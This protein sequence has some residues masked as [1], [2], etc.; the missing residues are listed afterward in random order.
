MLALLL[1][2]GS[3]G[4]PLPPAFVALNSSAGFDLLV[5]SSTLR[6]AYTQAIVHFV[7]QQDGGSCFRASASVVLNALAAYGVSPPDEPG[8]FWQT[9]KPRYWVQ[10]NVVNSS[11]AKSNCSTSPYPN[12]VGA[13]LDEA[14][15]AMGC[16]GVRVATLHARS[17]GFNSS[18]DLARLLSD[19]L[20][21]EGVQVIV[22]F[23]GTPMDG[24]VHGGHYSPV[25]AYHPERAMALVLDVSRYKY[26]PWWVPV[27][28]LWSGVD[29]LDSL[30]T[31]RGLM[32]VRPPAVAGRRLAYAPA[33]P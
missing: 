9:P 12:C 17:G 11:C 24:L 6:A 7:S 30:G 13:S 21:G 33:H 1:G 18:A 29:S 25:V 14:S 23:I 31:R 19:T 3:V 15:G 27:R 22:N 16:T 26:P 32:V 28:T 5:D 2:L 20:G 10:D 4:L 8:D